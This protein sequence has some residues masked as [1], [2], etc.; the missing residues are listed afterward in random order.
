MQIL[1]YAGPIPRPPLMLNSMDNEICSKGGQ[2][3]A[4]GPCLAHVWGLGAASQ[5]PAQ[6]WGGTSLM[7]QS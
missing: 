7:S 5:S 4:W 3:L 1:R 2:L 6:D